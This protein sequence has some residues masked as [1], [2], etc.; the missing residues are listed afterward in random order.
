[1]P[2]RPDETASKVRRA[3][4][5]L[6]CGDPVIAA[7]M[8]LL[9]LYYVCTRGIFE[10]KLSGDG[11][12]GFQYL[13]AVIFE[14][15]LD[16]QKVIPDKLP[17]FGTHP[18]TH[19]MP[20]R[21]P[22]GPVYIWMPFYLIACGIAKLGEL[23][24][25]VKAV[26]PD[27][28]FHAWITGLGT[29]GA[30]IVGYRQVYVMIARHLGQKPARLGATVAI[31]ATPIAWY[32]VTQPT[33]QHGC[34]FGVIALLLE[35]W[36][37]WRDTGSPRRFVILGLLGGLAMSMRAQEVLWLLLPAGEC[38]WKLLRG[39]DRLRWFW[40][41]VALGLAALVAFAPQLAIFW[42]YTASLSPPQAEPVRW[43]VPM[44]TVA[45]FSTRAGL[46]PWTPIAYL[47][48]VG[49]ALSRKGSA[50]TLAL[51]MFV[52]FVLEVYVCGAAWVPCGGY[53]YGARRLSDAAPL[54]GLGVALALERAGESLRWRRVVLGFSYLCIFL[55][56]FTMELQ[57]W[58]KVRS[59][60]AHA[61]S[62][63]SYFGELKAPPQV[64][65][66]LDVIGYPFVQPAGWLFALRH[67]VLPGAFEGV[68]G[69]LMLD[70]DGQWFTVLTKH[71]ALD[72]EHRAHVASGLKLAP[73]PPAIVDGPVRLL[74]GMFASEKIQV[75]VTGTIPEGTTTVLW[76]GS[77]RPVVRIA[78]G[79]QF[80]VDADHVDAGVNELKMDLPLGSQLK[81]LEFQS[82]SIWWR[83]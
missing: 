16:M 9:V 19:H 54:F 74:I 5:W 6:T 65:R 55:C 13:R 50:R 33:Y 18:V 38:G 17:F 81:T 79:I 58:G 26:R 67:R 22:F 30:V 28:P 36:D 70:R 49:I 44:I 53:A 31:W 78:T 57:R 68:V 27:S 12:Y 51:A 4:R 59:S 60:G 24:H 69:N 29:L 8:L 35:R 11:V 80:E 15:T 7:G 1:V 25:I 72:W 21:C 83:R 62:M 66:A 82:L 75:Q 32:A 41:G 14:G 71:F 47:T 37:A 76:N 40:C 61:R 45:L 39:P 56:L 63:G 3:L 34:A 23:L 10:G 46:F 73:R 2:S 52:V 20:N 48:L 64:Q 42:Y 77:Q 43:T